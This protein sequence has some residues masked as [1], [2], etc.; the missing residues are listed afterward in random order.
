[1]LNLW[2]SGLPHVFKACDCSG[3]PRDI[4][5]MGGD[6]T[7]MYYLNHRISKD[8]DIF[9]DDPQYLNFFLPSLNGYLEHIALKYSNLSN[10][11]KI[12]LENHEIDFI[13]A[14]NIT[15]IEPK[16]ETIDGF[17]IKMDDPREIIAKKIFYRHDSFTFRDVF[18]LAVVFNCD[19]TGL[20]S[21]LSGIDDNIFEV[22][23]KRI[24]A[25]WDFEKKN[26]QMEKINRL[27]D[28]EYLSGYEFEIC[29]HFLNA[30]CAR[31]DEKPPFPT[32][33]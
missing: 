10:F 9:L 6:T 26:P 23:D 2:K 13:V 31:N 25:L 20:I 27:P 12:S 8:I 30:I 4:L 19:N 24:N 22:L 33:L 18:D 14:G 28:Y 29:S 15:G 3:L 5:V 32:F 7:L 16:T 21:A 11:I 1:M 17:T